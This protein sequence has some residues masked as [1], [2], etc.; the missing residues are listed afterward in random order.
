MAEPFADRALQRIVE[1]AELY[2]RLVLLV[3]PAEGGKTAALK[4]VCKS[5]GGPLIKG[6]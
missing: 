6:E 2:Q 3:A 4:D 5:T 1:A